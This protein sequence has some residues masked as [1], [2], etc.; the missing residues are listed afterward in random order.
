M[1]LIPPLSHCTDEKQWRLEAGNRENHMTLFSFGSNKV[2]TL[3]FVA[4]LLILSCTERSV[5]HQP[6]FSSLFFSLFSFL[7]SRHLIFMKKYLIPTL[8][9]MRQI[10]RKNHSPPKLLLVH[11]IQRFLLKMEKNYISIKLYD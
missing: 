7:G 3:H 6:S 5:S 1:S 4:K 2:Y 8:F 11:T 10:S 9:C